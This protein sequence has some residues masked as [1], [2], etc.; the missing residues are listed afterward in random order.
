MFL[1]GNKQ[2][3]Y[4]Y[5]KESDIFV[6]LSESEACPMVFCEA[7]TLGTPVIT[8]NFGSSFEFLQSGYNGYVCEIDDVYKI[9]IDITKNVDKVDSLKDNLKSYKSYNDEIRKKLLE[10]FN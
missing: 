8:T 9:L 3:P 6:C 4:P 2:N 7:F 1:L 5:I 10:L